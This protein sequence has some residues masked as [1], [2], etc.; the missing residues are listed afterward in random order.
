MEFYV[1]QDSS[2]KEMHHRGQ[3]ADHHSHC[4]CWRQGVQD[5][6]RRSNEMKTMKVLAQGGG[7]EKR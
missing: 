4:R 6:H 2:T 7:G 1:V 5:A 3:E